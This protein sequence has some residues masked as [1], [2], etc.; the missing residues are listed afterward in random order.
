MPG[1]ELKRSLFGGGYTVG[2][3]CPN[4]KTR[5]KSP[6]EDA[7]KTDTCPD[8]QQPFVVPGAQER[9]QL[10]WQAEHEEAVRKRKVFED[11]EAQVELRKKQA[12]AEEDR[13][14]QSEPAF[15]EFFYD[16][17]GAEQGPLT[18][19]QLSERFQSAAIGA[20]TQV[21]VGKGGKT[22]SAA[23]VVDRIKVLA[24]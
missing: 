19:D 13:K 22:Y 11:Q 16:L 2:Y 18:A 3:E 21:R 17:N 5:L 1:I 14:L 9:D 24:G 4:C 6:L 12:R 10:R 7:G 15:V 8:C 20:D 23:A